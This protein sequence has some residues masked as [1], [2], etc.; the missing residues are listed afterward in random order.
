MNSNRPIK[1]LA[2]IATALMLVVPSLSPA[3]AAPQA[4]GTVTVQIV[5]FA[6]EP[7]EI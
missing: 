7:A 2:S 6:F 4:Q 1:I 5:S 3:L